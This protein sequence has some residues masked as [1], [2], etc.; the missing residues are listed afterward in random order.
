MIAFATLTRILGLGMLMAPFGAP[1][2][3]GKAAPWLP[4]I[5]Y[6]QIVSAGESPDSL[7]VISLQRFEAE[8][9]YLHEKGYV[10]LSTG[11]IVDF[12]RG[13]KAPHA[14]IVAIH[15]DDGWKSA[16]LALPV[17]DR[18][19][20]KATFWIIAGTGIGWP[21]MDWDEV[22]AIARQPRYEVQSHTMTHPWKPNDTLVDWVEGRTPGKGEKEAQWEIAESRRVLSQRLGRPIPYLAWPGGRYTERLIGLAEMSG[23]QALFT[24]DDGVNRPGDDL[25]RLKR[26]PIHGGCNQRVFARMLRDGVSRD[27]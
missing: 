3:A 8:M 15:F 6:H 7:E 23:Y 16:Q 11:E 2:M 26:T 24:I 4:I 9:R 25:L 20:F 13:R 14:K 10:T 21:H 12:V 17:L 5:V 27:C 19:G 18:Y 22:Q 1:A